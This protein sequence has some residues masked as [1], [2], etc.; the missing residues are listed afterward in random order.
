MVTRNIE[1]QSRN[2]PWHPWELAQLHHRIPQAEHFP[3]LWRL[4]S[5]IKCQ[6]VW[7]PVWIILRRMV[8]SSPHYVLDH[9]WCDAVP[10]IHFF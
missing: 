4:K 8:T 3:L 7:L 9:P 6:Q 10:K 1:L 2:D 5:N